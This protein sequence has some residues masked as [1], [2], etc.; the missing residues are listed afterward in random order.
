MPDPDFSKFDGMDVSQMISHQGGSSVWDSYVSQE[1]YDPDR[2]DLT[3]LWI[4]AGRPWKSP[5][6][7]AP[8][9]HDSLK[10]RFQG[11]SPDDPVWAP[12]STALMY[13]EHLD[14]KIMV[15]MGVAFFR[16]VDKDPAGLLMGAPDGAK[17]LTAMFATMAKTEDGGPMT[18]E[19]IMADVVERTGHLDMYEQETL[20]AKAQRALMGQPSI[21]S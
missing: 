6:R 7:W 14:P 1:A 3:L 19:R 18:A 2:I 4:A 13:A 12:Y 20:V 16:V 17:Q 8:K 5:R 21:P 9:T 11:K 10:I 15:A